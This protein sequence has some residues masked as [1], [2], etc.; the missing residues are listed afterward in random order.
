MFE[1]HFNRPGF[2]RY[3][4]KT[5]AEKPN[6][7]DRTEHIKSNPA[8]ISGCGQATAQRM[9]DGGVDHLKQNLIDIMI[10]S[11]KLAE[12]ARIRDLYLDGKKAAQVTERWLKK[13]DKRL[14]AAEKKR[15]G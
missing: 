11:A 3:A 9:A 12:E 15:P 10:A 8:Y 2:F 5:T 1:N 13:Y 7:N 4:Q 14:A 6:K